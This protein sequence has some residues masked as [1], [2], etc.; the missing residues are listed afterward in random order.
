M[1][2]TAGGRAP[3]RAA[4][5]YEDLGPRDGVGLLIVFGFSAVTGLALYLSSLPS[6]AAWLAGQALLSMALVQW[7][8]LLHEAGHGTL[9]KTRALGSLAGHLASFFCLIPF[10]SWQAVH[11]L[12][13]KWTGWQDLDPTT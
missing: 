6:V 8:V 12:H 1:S 2:D 11:G 9:F 3:G 4:E 13:H 7:F 10:R 5:K